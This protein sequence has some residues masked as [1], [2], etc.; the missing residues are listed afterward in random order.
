ML[1][2]KKELKTTVLHVEGMMCGHCAKHVEE[3]MLALGAKSA[4]VELEAKTVTVVASEKITSE[5][6]TAA[7][8]AAG[9]RVV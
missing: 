3:A 8:T 1:F 6:M 7:I 4:K 9:Y 2:A 5:K